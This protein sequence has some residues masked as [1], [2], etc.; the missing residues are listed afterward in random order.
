MVEIIVEQQRAGPGDLPLAGLSIMISTQVKRVSA[1]LESD[2]QADAGAI[3]HGQ[4]AAKLAGEAP[5][6]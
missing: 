2:A 4:R 1:R 6:D 3:K 5:H